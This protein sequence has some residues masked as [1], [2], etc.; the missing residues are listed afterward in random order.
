MD[1]PMDECPA[2]RSST[3]VHWTVFTPSISI[4]NRYQTI[5][6]T[7]P[8]CLV[9][10]KSSSS[11]PLFMKDWTSMTWV[12]GHM[13]SEGNEAVDK[14]AKEAAEFGS[15]E[16]QQLPTFLRRQL[17]NGLSGYLQQI[18]QL[19][20]EGNEKWWKRSKRYKRTKTI[21]PDLSAP[22]YI[23]VTNGL[24]RR[25]TSVLTQMRTGHDTLNK[26]LHRIKR[27]DSPG[28]PYCLNTSEDTTHVLLRCWKYAAL[29]HQLRLT[30]KRKAYSLQHLL[31]NRSAIRHTLNFLNKTGRLRATYRDISAELIDD[32]K[33]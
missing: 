20:K 4:M 32:D 22:N 8:A 11:S 18:A 21:D 15:S 2:L 24:N 23:K 25:Q 12:A 31:S 16:Q 1:H 10:N 33:C 29:R 7:S 30:L 14:L 5:V 3:E 27:A 17:P 28:C 13:N 6:R 9:D 26:H 19:S